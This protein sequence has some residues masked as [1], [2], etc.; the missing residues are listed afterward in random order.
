MSP[1]VSGKDFHSTVNLFVPSA[2]SILAYDAFPSVQ[3]ADG[4]EAPSGRDTAVQ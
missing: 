4:R 2:F 3:Q 1:S